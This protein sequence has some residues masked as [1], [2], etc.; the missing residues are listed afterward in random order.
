[1]R[2]PGPA[3]A[4]YCATIGGDTPGRIRERFADLAATTGIP[5]ETHCHNDLGM[6][7]GNSVAGAL[8]AP[9]PGRGAWV[10]T[11]VSG[12]GERAG[13]ADLL[14]CILAF[15]HGFDLAGR[16]DL[17]D[18]DLCWARR[19]GLWAAQAFGKPR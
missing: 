10:N 9:D 16:A 19:F 12:I 14:S 11:C 8:G 7:V 6:A 1:P 3:P 4:P 2:R 15:R 5:V 17:G 18:L 13:N